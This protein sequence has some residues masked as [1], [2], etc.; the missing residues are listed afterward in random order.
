MGK[1]APVP[2]PDPT[3]LDMLM[4]A[5]LFA[6]DFKWMFYACLAGFCMANGRALLTATPK[7]NYFHGCATMV[8]TCYGGSTLAAVMCGKPVAFVLNEALV[9]VCLTVWTVMYLLPG[10]VIGLSKDT[11]IGSILTPVSYT[12]LT[13]PTICSV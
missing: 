8:V 1:A 5:F 3:P 11:A 7:I 9:S 6:G 12:H 13:L 10:L 4:D 2:A